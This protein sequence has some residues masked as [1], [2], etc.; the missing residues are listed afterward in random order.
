MAYHF[1]RKKPL[2]TEI[3]RLAYERIDKAVVALQR[4]SESRPEEVHTARKCFK[5]IRALLKLV[6]HPMGSCYT[7]ENH[8]YR[9]VGRE[10]AALRDI[11][12]LVQ[13]WA[14]FS[15]K[16]PE[17]TRNQVFLRSRQRLEK[18]LEAKRHDA[19]HG[20]RRAIDIL[21][22]ARRRVNDWPLTHVS[23]AELVP[24]LR[25]TYKQG[26]RAMSGAC[27]SQDGLL[28]H[29][30]RKRTRDFWCH[31]TLLEPTSPEVMHAHRVQLKRL[32]DLLGEDHDLTVLRT[33]ICDGQFSSDGDLVRQ[34]GCRI[35]GVQSQ[36]RG[37]ACRLAIEV[38]SE[39]PKIYIHR[40]SE[41]WSHWA[42]A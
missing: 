23:F 25:L 41:Q 35:Q 21:E 13:N 5:E 3:R 17:L 8:S 15:R 24:G 36:L 38:Y 9:D 37:H 12:V 28:L 22:T 14:A 40:I 31:T 27:D 6:Q 4:A 18:E 42:G 29:E 34:L 10:L 20:V 2:A 11:Q 7:P 26:R 1:K 32:L 30:C 19:L 16:F 39:R 33:Y